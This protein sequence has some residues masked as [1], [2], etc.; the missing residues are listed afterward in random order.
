MTHG[1]PPE[2]KLQLNQDYESNPVSD[3]SNNPERK[4]K[5]T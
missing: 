3:Y 4:S 2:N 1:G 5:E